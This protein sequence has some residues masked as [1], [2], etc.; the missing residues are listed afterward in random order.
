MSVLR[1]DWP[2]AVDAPY[3]TRSARSGFSLPAMRRRPASQAADH[4]PAVGDEHGAAD[5]HALG[6]GPHRA[7][8]ACQ[9]GRQHNPQLRPPER[10]AD[11]PASS[12]AEWEVWHTGARPAGEALRAEGVRLG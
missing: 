10:L 3:G 4:R 7:Q 2:V 6:A 9:D 11:A 8:A 12:T 1:P 5:D